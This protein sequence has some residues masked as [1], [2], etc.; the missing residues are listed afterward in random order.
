MGRLAKNVLDQ[1]R[2][3]NSE[4]CGYCGAE[5]SYM[6]DL[7]PHQRASDDDKR[8]F[9]HDWTRVHICESC[10]NK[11]HRF[12][13][14]ERAEK[15]GVARGC[16]TLEQKKALCTG[17]SSV[18]AIRGA[19]F[20]VGFSGQLIVP[21]GIM[22]D[23]SDDTLFFLQGQRWSMDELLELQGPMALRMA[24]MPTNVVGRAF[25]SILSGDSEGNL[26]DVPKYLDLLEIPR[27]NNE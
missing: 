20:L 17:A 25:F 11:V 15:Y 6:W 22:R 5:K 14:V 26:H 7:T 21:N 16:M 8:S 10:W 13:W 24:G 27:A 9:P 19:K 2:I 12:N 4:G 23:T 3:V 1:Y 18:T